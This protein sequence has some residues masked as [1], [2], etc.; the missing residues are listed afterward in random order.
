MLAPPPTLSASEFGCETACKSDEFHQSVNK[1]QRGYVIDPKLEYY[2]VPMG[3]KSYPSLGAIA[4]LFGV[5]HPNKCR[6]LAPESARVRQ[7]P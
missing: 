3:T 2:L 6:I 1:I 4:Q 5:L 7:G